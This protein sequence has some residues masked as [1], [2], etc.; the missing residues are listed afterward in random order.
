MARLL[1]D[2]FF[3][4]IYYE[5]YPYLVGGIFF[6]SFVMNIVH[7]LT[8]V[9]RNGYGNLVGDKLKLNLNGTKVV[10]NRPQMGL[11]YNF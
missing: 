10:Q 6:A 7:T 11:F 2:N 4:I 3:C 9:S 1:A 8:M 5:L